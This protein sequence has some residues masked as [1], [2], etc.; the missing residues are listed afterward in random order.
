MQMYSLVKKR[1][2]MFSVSFRLLRLRHSASE[3]L[4]ACQMNNLPLPPVASLRLMKW[5]AYGS[6]SLLW[7]SEI[8]DDYAHLLG[9][10]NLVVRLVAG[11]SQFGKQ[12][13]VALYPQA[14]VRHGRIDVLC[15]R[16]IEARQLPFGVRTNAECRFVHNLNVLRV[17][18]RFR[19]TVSVMQVKV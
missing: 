15:F 9:R 16:K 10:E 5:Q 7:L 4:A 14:E 17:N 13:V 11:L 2:P 12:L 1:F 6:K 19:D 3:Q 18:D 8:A